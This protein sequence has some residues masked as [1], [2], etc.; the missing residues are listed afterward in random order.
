MKIIETDFGN[1]SNWKLLKENLIEFTCNEAVDDFTYNGFDDS[2]YDELESNITIYIR[3]GKEIFISS[4]T[5]SKPQIKFFNKINDALN[6]LSSEIYYSEIANQQCE[7]LHQKQLRSEYYSS[8][9]V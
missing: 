3:S 2:F 5:A 1:S 7:Q 9:G 6:H 8:R 4:E